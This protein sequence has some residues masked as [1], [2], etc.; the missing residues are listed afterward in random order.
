VRTLAWRRHDLIQQIR[1]DL[2]RYLTPASTPEEQLLEAAALLQMP[3]TDL[4]AVGG[5]QFL[6]SDELGRLLDGMP[7]LLRRLATTT[8]HEE[9]WSLERIR[10][11]IQWG[12]T[13]GLRHA[14]GLSHLYVT[15]PTRRAYQTPE[16]EMLV[17]LLDETV[18][19]G[20]LSGWHRSTSEA[21]GLV[22]STRV[23]QAERWRQSRMLAEVDRQPITPKQLSR[24]RAG[25][26]R[27]RY[28]AVLD[29]FDRHHQLIGVLD[30]AAIREAVE[31]HG[32][33]ARDDPTLFELVCTF[34]VLNA[35]QGM[36]WKL[37]RLR[38][39]QGSL[40]IAG[41]RGQDKIEVTY[42]ST[43]RPLSA[44]S[45]Y[46]DVQRRHALE[47]GGLIPDLVIHRTGE[48]ALDHWLLVEV[49]GGHRSVKK[50]ARAA[51]YDLLAYRMAFSRVLDE[52]EGPYGLGIAWGAEL[53]AAEDGNM[54]LCT[55]DM[56]PDAL[57]PLF[58]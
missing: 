53:P 11:S 13:I 32:L 7:S 18:R 30:R 55:P 22:V 27:R 6:T 15:A 8:L 23:T 29:A 44:G 47:P 3:A 58:G 21:A 16:N 42:Q 36:G 20:R 19:L 46:R 43:P 35:L 37:D 5:L 41:Q 49:K 10:G 28:Q 1:A 34:A 45:L 24:V 2:W 57:E 38:L 33:V 17:F 51:A 14:T 4:R 48:G 54:R 25:R 50:S 12:R 9:E 40:R 31:R 39:F 52:I 26:F 56:L